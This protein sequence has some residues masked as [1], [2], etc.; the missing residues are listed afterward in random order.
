MH[1]S[2]PVDLDLSY[3]K[4]A[5]NQFGDITRVNKEMLR[6]IQDIGIKEEKGH[7]TSDDITKIIRLKEDLQRKVKEEEIKWR[8]RS[9][10]RWLRE[11]EENT[12]FFHGL[13]STMKRSNRISSL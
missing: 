2:G 10:C 8:Q 4:W 3:I 11:G 13:A 9:Q 5:R 6:N 1:G 7:I 12:R